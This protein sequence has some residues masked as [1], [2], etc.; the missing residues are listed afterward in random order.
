MS[1][2]RSYWTAADLLAA[3]LPEPR[4]AVDTII[5]EG[6]TLLV[7]S[8]KV[9]KSWWALVVAIAVALGGRALGTIPV[10]AGDVL[11]LALEDGPRRLRDRLKLVLEGDPAPERLAFVTRAPRIDED[12]AGF[13]RR[14]LDAA[15]HPR[16]IVIDVLAKVRPPAG[17]RE[18]MYAADYATAAPL[19]QLA[20]EYGVAILLVHHTRKATSDDF[21]DAVSGT[22]GLAGAAD[23]VLVLR[24]SR[25]AADAVLA[26]TGRDISEAEHA[27][28]FDP[29]LCT[30]RMLGDARVHA[31][32]PERRAILKVVTEA[33]SLRPKQIAEASDVDYEVVKK[34]V[35]KMAE[36]GD[37]VTDG[38][39]TYMPVP[40]VPSVPSEGQDRERREQGEW[41]I[42]GTVPPCSG[43]GG[44]SDRTS[45]AGTRWCSPCWE[46]AVGGA[47]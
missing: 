36:A 47:A 8:P 35:V 4:F 42:G 14:W 2:Y 19:Q 33:G 23:A 41:H 46:A 30:W 31:L 45:A 44:P 34:L 26:V 22:Q 16:L 27:L 24:R 39:G 25:T 6:L 1:D 15:E 29:Q 21:L 12:L 18:S 11:Y 3:D 5:P 20:T 40:S 32:S 7:G 13:L 10:V 17:N 37:L 9:G 28:T 43:C 38:A